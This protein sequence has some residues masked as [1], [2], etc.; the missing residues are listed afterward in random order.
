MTNCLIDLSQDAVYNL[1]INKN[2]DLDQEIQAEIYSGNTLVGN[3]D[4]NGYTGATL[5]V[6]IKPQDNF[7]IL[8]FSTADG[9]I[10]LGLDGIF[11]LFKSSTQLQNI[12]A[13]TFYYDMYLSSPLQSK[14]AFLRGQFII[15]QNVG[16]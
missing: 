13:G 12:Q 11:K 15:I 9:S 7:N 6:K 2:R 8:T 16:L 4:F 10:V 1:Q 3:F 5:T 14:R